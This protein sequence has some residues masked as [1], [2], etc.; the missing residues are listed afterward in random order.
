MW[1]PAPARGSTRGRPCA[2]P[3]PAAAAPGRS[4]KVGR[5][6]SRGRKAH[7]AA[8]ATTVLTPT[9]RHRQSNG[10]PAGAGTTC[11][12]GNLRNLRNLRKSDLSRPR[13]FEM[14]W[15]FKAKSAPP[16]MHT[17]EIS[18]KTGA[19]RSR[20]MPATAR[21]A[22]AAASACSTGCRQRGAATGPA[23]TAS[24][25]HLKHTGVANPARHA[26]A[27]MSQGPPYVT[28]AD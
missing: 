21:Q 8:A 11:F 7:L 24:T 19:C 23:A 25:A 5:P 9:R 15:V 27:R 12:A 20:A 18:S 13:C 10:L 22:P 17:W 28:P 1:A 16:G 2:A 6:S 14:S 26:G 4:L 3:P